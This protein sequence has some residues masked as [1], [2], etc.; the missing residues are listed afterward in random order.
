MFSI[1]DVKNYVKNTSEFLVFRI[2]GF[3]V[4]ILPVSGV[5]LLGNCIGYLCA[6]LFKFRKMEVESHLTIA[7]PEKG[8]DWKNKISLRSY[9]HLAREALLFL[10]SPQL[11]ENCL[12]KNVVIEGLE[13]LE[14]SMRQGSGVMIVSGHLGNWEMGVAA[15]AA[16]GIPVDVVVQSQRNPFIDECLLDLRRRMGIGVITSKQG[17]YAVL[18]S[19]RNGR[20]TAW[21]GDQSPGKR[22]VVVD[23]LGVP[24]NTPKGCALLALRSGAPLFFAS[25]IAISNS[26]SR[27]R[28]ELQK[29]SVP[30]KQNVAEAVEQLTQAHAKLLGLAIRR[31]PDQ[32]LWH[33]RRWKN[34]DR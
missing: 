3:F 17:P 29:I 31:N 25:S 22:S 1:H 4:R 20:V 6:L 5:L 7:F 26:E 19:L 9:K 33:H 34:R 23:F 27:Y 24:S 32:Y 16:R 8:S 21:L 11:D 28:L 18:K 12:R 14:E 2:I 15:L 10:R 13:V 30:R